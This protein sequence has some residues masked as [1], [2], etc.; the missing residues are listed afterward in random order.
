MAGPKIAGYG[1][2]GYNANT[3]PRVISTKTYSSDYDPKNSGA[4]FYYKNLSTGKISPEPTGG[5][6]FWKKVANPN[7]VAPDTR[8]ATEKLSDEYQNAYNEAKATNEARYQQLLADNTAN[9][10]EVTQ[11]LEGYGTAQKA[12]IA[13]TYKQSLSNSIQNLAGTG[14]YNT[15]AYGTTQTGNAKAQASSEAELNESINAQKLNAYGSINSARQGIIENR[16]DDYPDMSAFLNL[17]AQ[18][19]EYGSDGSAT[20]SYGTGGWTT[21][22]WGGQTLHAGGGKA[23]TSSFKNTYGREPITKLKTPK[24]NT[25]N[26]DGTYKA[27]TLNA[28]SK[29]YK[30]SKKGTGTVANVLNKGTGTVANVLNK[31]IGSTLLSKGTSIAK[32]AYDQA[33]NNWAVKNA[34]KQYGTN[35]MNDY[36]KRKNK[37]SLLNYDLVGGI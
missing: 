3:E 30:N 1:L 37:T 7:Y 13:D 20:K 19:G 12:K 10:A 31:G 23:R 15:T 2:K 34:L 6:Q 24:A 16:T 26:G 29:K 35:L 17:M 36:N 22:L 14:L 25:D 32:N 5:E 8:T 9:K 21:P 27:S 33:T 4:Q 11:L 18:S 28:L